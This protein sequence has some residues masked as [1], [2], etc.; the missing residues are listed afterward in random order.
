MKKVQHRKM[1][2]KFEILA[3]LKLTE[4]LVKYT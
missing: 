4:P 1:N 2:M 3:L